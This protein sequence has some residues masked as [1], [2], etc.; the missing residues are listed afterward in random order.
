M[1]FTYE[2]NQFLLDGQPCRILSGAMHYFRIV[3]QYW[4]AG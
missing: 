2:G 3:S 4:E 1:N